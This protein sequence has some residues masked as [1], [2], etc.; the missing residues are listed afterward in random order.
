M[1]NRIVRRDELLSVA[2]KMA[3]KIASYHPNAVRCAK[4]AVVRGADLPLAEGLALEKRL[5][6]RLSVGAGGRV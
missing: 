2:E 1:V 5:A 6:S 3:Q 4:E